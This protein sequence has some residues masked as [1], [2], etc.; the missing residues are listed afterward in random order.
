[1]FY[2]HKVVYIQYLGEVG[3]FFILSK[4]FLPLYNSGKI[5]KIYRDFP[6]L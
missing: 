1:M 3:I 4:T 2:F 5:I 6:K